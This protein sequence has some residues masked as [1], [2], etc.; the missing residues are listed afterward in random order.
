MYIF[1]RSYRQRKENFWKKTYAYLVLDPKRKGMETSNL[2][3]QTIDEKDTNKDLE[4]NLLNRGIMIL[5]SS[6]NLKKE[7]VVPA[8]YI[9]QT[10][11]ILFGFSKDNLNIL[12]LS[13]HSKEALKGF[14][15]MQFLALI[16][17]TKIKKVIGKEYILS[18]KFF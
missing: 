12:P 14:L 9:R 15:F 1:R 16:A 3:L 17:F 11:E 8:Y 18:R 4:Y 10:A 6:F 7:E 13:I 2:I 5:I